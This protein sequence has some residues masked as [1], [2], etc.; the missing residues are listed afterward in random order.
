MTIKSRIFLMV[1]VSFVG[2]TSLFALSVLTIRKVKVTGPIYTD[3]VRGKDLAADIL[4][5]P[6]YIL[7]S[8][9]TIQLAHAASDPGERQ[10]LFDEFK[11]LRKEFDERQEFWKKELPEG[12][13]KKVLLEDVH[14]PAA[15]FY[16]EAINGYFPALIKGDAK[17]ANLLL[18][19]SLKENYGKHRKQVDRLVQLVDALCK[20]DEADAVSTLKISNGLIYLVALLLLGISATS[21]FFLS[22]SITKP[23]DRCVA[24]ANRLATGDLT[25]NISVDSSD[26]TG[27]LLAAMK[28]MLE[29]LRELVLNTVAISGSIASASTQLHTTSDQIATGAQQAASQTTTVA[30][31]SEEMAHTS[32]DIARNCVLAVESSHSSSATAANGAAIVQ[33]T[34]EG[35]TRIADRVKD[36]AQVV[37]TLGNRSDQIGEIIATIEDIADQTNLLA[38]NAAI[39]AARAGEQGRG[40]AVVADE[41][42]ALAERTT[43]ATKEIGE[44]IKAIQNETRDV[45]RSMEEGV[46][47]VERGADSS[48]KSGEALQQI[49][50]QIN[51][52][53]M[54]IHQIATAAEEQTATTGEITSN[55]HQVSEVVQDAARGAQETSIAAAQLADQARELQNLVSN[56]RL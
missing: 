55:V 40:F 49:L 34:I 25:E 3:I 30:S 31:A 11:K 22:R 27:R 46:G 54:Q 14:D 47:E 44:M 50:N 21:S 41:V 52:V 7:E 2:L 28:N 23:L 19:S 26:E 35:M 20:K 16:D 33:E 56:F 12:E 51:D 38:L 29:K 48:K 45:V 24:I 36:T 15:A 39:E 37:G 53:T 6:E 32:S 42:R 1:I 43:K 9:L 10:R 8:Y 13:V 17:K 18:Q 5:P 4:P